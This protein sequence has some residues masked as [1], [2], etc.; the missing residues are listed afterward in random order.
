[1]Y[2]K[3]FDSV[4]WLLEG[5]SGLQKYCFS[6][7]Q[8]FLEVFWDISENDLLKQLRACFCVQLEGLEEEL[9]CM[10]E[11]G[12]GG[13][14]QPLP[15]PEGMALSSSDVI[16]SLNEHL[17]VALQVFFFHL[18]LWYSG[19]Y[20]TAHQE[21]CIAWSVSFCALLS[22]CSSV[23]AEFLGTIDPMKIHEIW[24][25]DLPFVHGMVD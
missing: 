12:A 1:M 21:L 4:G 17:I 24:G 9:K 8:R 19:F 6:N 15:L 2:L 14:F 22:L 18:F 13:F 25:R 3:C 20:Y 10:R 7:V 11:T 16:A 23:S 5:V